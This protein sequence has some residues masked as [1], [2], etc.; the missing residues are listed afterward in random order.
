MLWSVVQPVLSA[1]V[2]RVISDS[3]CGDGYERPC[4]IGSFTFDSAKGFLNCKPMEI[5]G[6][7]PPGSGLPGRGRKVHDDRAA[8]GDPQERGRQRHWYPTIPRPRSCSTSAIGCGFWSS[9]KPCTWGRSPRPLTHPKGHSLRWDEWRTHDIENVVLKDRNDPTPIIWSIGNHVVEQCD[10]TK[11][12]LARELAPILRRLDSTRL[13]ASDSDNPGPRNYL[14]RASALDLVGF[15]CHHFPF[16]AFPQTFPGKGS[17]PG[18]QLAAGH[19]RPL[20]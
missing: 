19:L 14:I 15:N 3:R 16:E 10:S 18:G 9:M 17:S 2:Y 13:F 12:A 6:V 5:L 1:A 4:G 8:A 7:Q 20:P 11:I